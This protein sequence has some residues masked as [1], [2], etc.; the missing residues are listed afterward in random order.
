M[1][2]SL[3]LNKMTV[4]E[5]LATMELLW[6]DLCRCPED[7]PA[8]PWHGKVLADREKSISEGKSTFSDL[9]KAKERIRNVTQ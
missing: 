6:E 4:P 2:F 9:N 8:C 7:I 1:G 5:K 3:P